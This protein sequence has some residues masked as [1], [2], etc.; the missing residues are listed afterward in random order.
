MSDKKREILNH[1]NEIDR[2]KKF[3]ESRK[4]TI[5]SYKN[6]KSA[7]SE[8]YKSQIARAD[9]NDKSKLRDR[10]KHELENFAK[11]IESLKR[12]IINFKDQISKQRD[13]IARLKK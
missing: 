11:Q 7:V 1:R 5:Q 6:N 3:I 9:K 10:K 2:I 8:R 4:D 13:Y 12:E